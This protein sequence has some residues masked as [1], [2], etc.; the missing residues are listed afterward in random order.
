MGK[1]QEYVC[2]CMLPSR[3]ESMRRH[4]QRVAAGSRRMFHVH[5]LPISALCRKHYRGSRLRT[6]MT[7]HFSFLVNDRVDL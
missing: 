7:D 2:E 4:C 6:L 1:G 5:D 3:H